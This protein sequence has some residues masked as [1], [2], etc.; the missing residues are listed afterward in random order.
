MFEGLKATWARRQALKAV[1]Q[2][3]VRPWRRDPASRRV[4]FVL[5]VDE[6]SAKAAWRFIERFELHPKQVIPVVP[7]G[8]VTYAPFQFIGRVHSLRSKD[9]NRVGLP[10]KAFSAKLWAEE[11]D[12]AFCLTPAFDVAAALLVGASPATFRVGFFSEEAEPFYDL[13]V[14][15]QGDEA[16]ASA[17]DTLLK[18]LRRIEPPV[19][20][21]PADGPA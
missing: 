2:R 16:F 15:R 3:T 18:A 14:S 5:P 13:M 20:A 21:V 9:V 19:L 1:R 10:S 12:V 6:A 7:S 8:E 11:P 4:L 17:L